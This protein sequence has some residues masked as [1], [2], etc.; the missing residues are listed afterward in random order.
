MC[1]AQF[2]VGIWFLNLGLNMFLVPEVSV[3]FGISLSLKFL[4][5]LVF[6]L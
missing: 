3:K 4:I 6:H 5:N 1:V 2:L